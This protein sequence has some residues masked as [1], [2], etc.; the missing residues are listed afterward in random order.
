MPHDVVVVGS[1]NVDLQLSVA[2]HPLPGETL[3][4]GG[5]SSTPGGKGANQ[6]V[7]AALQ[8]ATTALI[9]A[10]GDDVAAETALRELR[11]AGVD[12]S[13]VQV[14]P[15]PTGLAV[16]TVAESGENTIIVV[17]GANAAVSTELVEANRAAL[18]AAGLCVLQAEIPLPVMAHC[19]LLA[20]GL[21]TRVILNAAPATALSA[22]VLR[23]ADPL[24]VNE[25]E[26][27]IVLGALTREAA[28]A[29]E[30]VAAA[31]ATAQA[32]RAQGARSVL[33][34]LGAQGVVGAEEAGTWHLPAR[35][36]QT[37]D[38][39]GAGDAFVG[40]LAAGLASGRSLRDAAEHATRV[41]AFSVGAAGAQV[42]YP[43]GTDPLP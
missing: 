42:S 27:G 34:T 35:P 38:T 17:P 10:V 39:T 43:R 6:A 13:R 21:G 16:V 3:M 24:V 14:A 31:R 22:D 32:L 23:T 2:R 26:A 25:H 20:H 40:A 28:P 11:A 30:S 15:G 29:P 5:G 41:A 19:A 9:G 4:G 8:G 36:V 18:G 7:A 33:L 37:V 1:I 12:L